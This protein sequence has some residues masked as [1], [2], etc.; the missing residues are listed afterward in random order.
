MQVEQRRV[1]DDANVLPVFD[2]HMHIFDPAYPMTANAGFLPDMFTVEDYLTR[3]GALPVRLAGGAVVS[4]ST[5]GFDQFYL[6]AALERLGPGWVGVTQ[7]PATVTDEELVALDATGVR[8]VRFNLHRGGRG[9]LDDLAA[10][11]RRVHTTVGWHVE[12]Y[13]D[14]RDLDDLADLVASL[15]AASIDHLG[16]SAAGL[17]TLVKLAE[18]GV[19][20][21]ASGF[22]RTD[23]NIGQALRRLWRANPDA[24]LFGTDLPCPRAPRPFADSDLDVVLDTLGQEAARRVLHDNA[25]AFYRPHA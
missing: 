3:V 4:A 2:S 5:Q 8:A 13:V 23:F 16:L 25:I 12:L 14:A 21:K 15:P 11:A 17:T 1:P 24:L 10:T 7:V 18:A 22:G 9:V 6:L 19:R 20:V